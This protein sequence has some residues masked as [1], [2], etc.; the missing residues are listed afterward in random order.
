M[1]VRGLKISFKAP[2]GL[3]LTQLDIYADTPTVTN[4]LVAS[5]NSSG[6]AGT[7]G[8]ST[9][10]AEIFDDTY[11][12]CVTLKITWGLSYQPPTEGFMSVEDSNGL[13]CF[14]NVEVDSS[15]DTFQHVMVGNLEI[16][17]IYIGGLE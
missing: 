13:N 4:K 11:I 12:T 3:N 2:V 15:N 9:G 1:G 6:I 16:A 8:I 7:N 5:L 14:P 17:E 10:Y